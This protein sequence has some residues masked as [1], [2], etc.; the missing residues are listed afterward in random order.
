M[1]S[2]EDRKLISQR[3]KGAKNQRFESFKF[4]RL[5]FDKAIECSILLYH[6]LLYPLVPLYPSI[7]PSF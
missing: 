1:S 4:K 3:R 2:N 6:F 5:T 7:T